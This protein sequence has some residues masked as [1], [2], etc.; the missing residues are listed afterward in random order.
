MCYHV[1]MFHVCIEFWWNVFICAR[2]IWFDVTHTRDVCQI[3]VH[4]VDISGMH[5]FCVVI[6][7]DWVSVMWCD[8]STMVIVMVMVNDEKSRQSSDFLMKTPSSCWNQPTNFIPTFLS[9]FSIYLFC[10]SFNCLFVFVCVYDMI[11]LYGSYCADWCL[12]WTTW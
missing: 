9:I 5:E 6:L 2:L 7:I 12:E 3:A 10:L 8:D 11:L 1:F 4:R